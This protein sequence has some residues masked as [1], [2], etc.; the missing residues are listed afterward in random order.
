MGT[1]HIMLAKLTNGL[2]FIIIL[3]ANFLYESFFCAVYLYLQI[4]LVIFWRKNIVDKAACRIDV[5]D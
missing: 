1:A 3:S 5:I 2:N 4:G